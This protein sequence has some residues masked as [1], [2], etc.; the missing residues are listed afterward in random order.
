[1]GVAI[2]VSAPTAYWYSFHRQNNLG[3]PLDSISKAIFSGMAIDIHGQ[4]GGSMSSEGLRFLDGD[5]TLN[6]QV[7]ICFAD[8][9]NVNLAARSLFRYPSKF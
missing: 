8:S 3:Y 4:F 6:N 9:V 2:F 5:T 7:D 1:M